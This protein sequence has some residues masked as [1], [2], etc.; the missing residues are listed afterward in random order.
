MATPQQIIYDTAMKAGLSDTTAKLLVGQSAHETGNW[1]SNAY[2][3]H[4][5]GFGYTYYAGSKWQT[6]NKGLIADNNQ[7]VADYKTLSDSTNELVDW[8]KRRQAEGKFKIDDLNTPE[9][10]AK[11][12]K[13]N[14]YYGAS[15]GTYLKGMISG[16]QK[17][18]GNLTT[19]KKVG[20]GSVL[21]LGTIFYIAFRYF[22]NK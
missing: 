18:A 15:Y 19:T 20:I 17:W 11:A 4:N 5:N 1:T 16:I 7:P 10:Y 8:L 22:K 12:L 14:A 3:N 13:D 21:I 9:K 6:G 2:K